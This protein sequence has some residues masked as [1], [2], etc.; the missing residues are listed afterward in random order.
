MKPILP[1]GVKIITEK[2]E[3]NG[4]RAQKKRRQCVRLHVGLSLPKSD[5]IEQ[6]AAKR[7][8]PCAARI[9]EQKPRS[10][11]RG[12]KGVDRPTARFSVQ[13]HLFCGA[14]K[15]GREKCAQKI[16]VAEKNGGASQRAEARGVRPKR[17]RSSEAKERECGKTANCARKRQGAANR[18]AGKAGKTRQKDGKRENCRGGGR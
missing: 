10:T 4:K 2:L 15:S 9:G 16:G 12:A 17:R 13:A 8:D 6:A 14:K 11:K 1:N 5:G 7:A 3:K 18:G